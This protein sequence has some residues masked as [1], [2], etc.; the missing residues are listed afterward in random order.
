MTR[1]SSSVSSPPS[2]TG[3]HHGLRSQRPSIVI[4]HRCD[5][6]PVA[7]LRVAAD[8]SWA[9]LSRY[10]MC[11]TQLSIHGACP[12]VTVL[13]HA[14]SSLMTGSG[15]TWPPC[16][17]Y[18]ASICGH[19]NHWPGHR[20]VCTF[21]ELLGNQAPPPPHGTSIADSRLLTVCR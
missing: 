21:Q 18:K 2:R 20:E 12:G 15:P 4:P 3:R 11:D 14:A 17:N 19:G 5:S 9:E 7:P 6:V 13:T 1:R 16:K 10:V 8:C